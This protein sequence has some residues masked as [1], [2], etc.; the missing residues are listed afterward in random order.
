M[1]FTV[2]FEVINQINHDDMLINEKKSIRS[3]QVSAHNNER[4]KIDP[5]YHAKINEI[6]LKH[7]NNKYANDPEYRAKR[8]AYY[9]ANKEKQAEYYKARRALKKEQKAQAKQALI[10]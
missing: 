3:K 6:T 2:L 10:I 9:Q 8:L 7:N 4:Y 5:V 1:P